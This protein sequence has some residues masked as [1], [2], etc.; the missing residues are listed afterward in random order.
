MTG[1]P[2]YNTNNNGCTGSATMI[3]AKQLVEAGSDCVMALG[4]EKM[5]RG[6]LGM[7]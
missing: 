3:L 1:I 4:F 5:E 2:I 7:K 6:T